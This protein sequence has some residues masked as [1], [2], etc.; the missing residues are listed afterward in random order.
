[1]FSQRSQ[2]HVPP[3]VTRAWRFRIQ[4]LE[5]RIGRLPA[6]LLKKL[7]YQPPPTRLIRAG[8][9]PSQPPQAQRLVRHAAITILHTPTLLQAVVAEFDQSMQEVPGSLT[10]AMV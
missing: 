5:T 8:Q 6:V 2:E 1:V 3:L 7:R 4:Q 10:D 9:I